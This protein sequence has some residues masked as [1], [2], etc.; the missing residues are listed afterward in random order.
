MVASLILP[1]GTQ[2]PSGVAAQEKSFSSVSKG[3][4]SRYDKKRSIKVK[5]ASWVRTRYNAVVESGR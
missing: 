4:H 3:F 2:R 1:V 5:S